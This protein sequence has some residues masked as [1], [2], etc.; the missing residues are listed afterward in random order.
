MTRARHARLVWTLCA[1]LCGLIWLLLGAESGHA[2]GL[3]TPAGTPIRPDREARGVLRRAEST[4]LYR[5]EGSAGQAV[6]ITVEADGFAPGVRLFGPDGGFIAGAGNTDPDPARRVAQLSAVI[7]PVDGVYSVLISS[8]GG[9]GG[10]RLLVAVGAAS[11]PT[12]TLSGPL[13]PTATLPPTLTPLPT[14]TPFMTAQA[15]GVFQPLTSGV[16]AI[17]QLTQA[18]QADRFAFFAA[19][20][21]ALSV[22][23]FAGLGNPT[24]RLELYA[25]DGQLAKSATGAQAVILAYRVPVS[26]AYI[27][28]VRAASGRGGY[29]LIANNAAFLRERAAGSLTKGVPVSDALQRGDQAVWRV[30]VP[31]TAQVEIEIVPEGGLTPTLRIVAPDGSEIL[32]APAFGNFPFLAPRAGVYSVQVA[33]PEGDSR[34]Q[35]RFQVVNV[36]PTP[37]FGPVTRGEDVQVAEGQQYTTSFAAAA[38][39]LIRVSA[40]GVADFDPVI[41]LY[42]PSGARIARSD[43]VAEGDP[44]A[45]L[46]TVAAEGNGVYVVRLFGYALMSG[47]ARLEIS[48]SR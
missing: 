1:A 39:S 26:G 23:A 33:A 35:L 38:G 17:G 40:A 7:L 20:G 16:P 25:P 21:E 24:L 43:D 47:S 44:R 19:A 14:A 10:Y 6:T 12:P 46:Q 15:G 27:V 18:G 8:A 32:S 5:F 45:A 36:A 3:P 48:V 41:E 37:T 34:Y 28:F 42:G 13:S 9:V 4:D 11:S 30:E 22:G 2:Q 29:T 31:A